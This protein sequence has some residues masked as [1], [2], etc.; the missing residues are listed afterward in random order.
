MLSMPPP[1][2]VTT[3]RC[4]TR[5]KVS[6]GDGGAQQ[7]VR[8][9]ASAVSGR[10]V[11]A[12]GDRVRVL[13][14]LVVVR[15]ESGNDASGRRPGGLESDEVVRVR[16][17]QAEY[18]RDAG[19]ADGPPD[20]PVDPRPRRLVQVRRKP[21]ITRRPQKPERSHRPVETSLQTGSGCLRVLRA[22]GSDAREGGRAYFVEPRTDHTSSRSVGQHAEEVNV[23]MRVA[24]RRTRGRG[25][26]CVSALAATGLLAA[27][28]G[29]ATRQIT[30]ADDGAA[31]ASLA[32]LSPPAGFVSEYAL[33]SRRSALGARRCCNR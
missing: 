2:D 24:S 18:D 4:R 28:S 29:P 13:A 16:P 22:R 12:T 30:A 15:V 32:S 23:G 8:A 6:D 26:G 31:R 7:L 3:S 14:F 33:P 21:G 10:G 1:R 5:W 11:P 19:E 9:R 17:N 20:E 25:R 27:C